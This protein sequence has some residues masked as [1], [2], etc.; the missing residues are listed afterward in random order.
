MQVER[1]SLRILEGIT[2]KQFT[3]EATV[4]RI[5]TLITRSG[6]CPGSV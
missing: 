6:A 3:A 2:F 4:L 1:K 5:Q